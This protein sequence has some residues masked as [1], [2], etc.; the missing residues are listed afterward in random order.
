ML[1]IY[2]YHYD[3]LVELGLNIES[4]DMIL[5]NV[6]NTRVLLTLANIKTWS[7]LDIYAYLFA[8]M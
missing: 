4:N 7:A 2:H 1:N 8:A 3:A 5:I 6:G